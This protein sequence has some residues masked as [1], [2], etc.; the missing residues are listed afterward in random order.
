MAAAIIGVVDD[1]KGI[2]AALDDLLQ[3]AGFRVVTFSSAKALLSSVCLPMLACLILDLHMP[4]M[5]GLTLQRHLA[6]AGFRVPIIVLTALGDSEIQAR[7]LDQGAVA[8]LTKPIDSE[9][10]L[11]AVTRAIT[12]NF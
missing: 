8:F 12:G 9:L 2:R 11:A 3:S 1:D 7:A 4:G 6:D 5:D 10:I